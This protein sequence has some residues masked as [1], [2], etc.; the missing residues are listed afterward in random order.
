MKFTEING[1]LFNAPRGYYLAHCIS[2]D[3]ALGAGI[4]RQFNNI[5]N[6]RFKL[7]KSYPLKNGEEFSY[8]HRA[9]LIDNVFNLVTKARYWHK[10]TYNS[11]Y[12]ALVD[13][14]KQCTALNI[15]KLAMPKI[16]AGLDRLSWERVKNI[17]KNVFSET[18][19]D[20]VV[21]VL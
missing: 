3:F 6:M 8:V 2:G 18:D 17:I 21:Y 15:T 4:A 20:I 9:L 5:Y 14:K 10:P 19:I 12:Q 1:N 16:G 7:F 11:L 13:M